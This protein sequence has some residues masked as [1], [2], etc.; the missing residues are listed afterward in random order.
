M[1]VYKTNSLQITLLQDTKQLWIECKEKLETEDFKAGLMKALELGKANNVRHWLIDARKIGE[2]SEADESWVQSEF[3]PH[4][5]QENNTCYI[6]MVIAP[7]C[8]D[9]MLLE[10]GWF[11]LKSYNS[12]IKINTFYNLMDA[13]N[14]LGSY[15]SNKELPTD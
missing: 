14:W 10:N 11:G 13:E 7:N 15:A 5:M 12:F 8:Y 9:R 4:L 2:L 3:F 1:A 6:A